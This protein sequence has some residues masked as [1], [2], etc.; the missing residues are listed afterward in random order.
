MVDEPVEQMAG[1]YFTQHWR[2]RMPLG[3]AFWG[4]TIGLSIV[5]VALLFFVAALFISSSQNEYLARA[6]VSP[7]VSVPALIVLV[8]AIVGLWRS[9]RRYVGPRWRQAMARM[10]A[11]VLSAFFGLLWIGWPIQELN[12]YFEA[13]RITREFVSEPGFLSIIG[14]P[15]NEYGRRGLAHLHL[16]EFD[17]ALADFSTAIGFHPNDGWAYYQRGYAYVR[18][19]GDMERACSDFKRASELGFNAAADMLKICQSY[20]LSPKGTSKTPEKVRQSPPK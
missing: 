15:Y 4:N 10:C 12:N 5:F 8:W 1:G 19:R 9:A 17:L 18:S 6:I 13:R 11:V 14:D 7:L 20:D 16:G 2:G 3:V